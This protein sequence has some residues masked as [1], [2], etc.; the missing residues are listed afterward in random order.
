MRM[1]APVA[2]ALVLA[3]ARSTFGQSIDISGEPFK[4][5]PGAKAALIVFSD[6]QCAYS[7]GFAKLALPRLEADYLRTGKVRYV[8]RDLPLASHKHAF[9]A[10][11]AA[12]CA[13]A[14]GR[15]W[16]MHDLLF[17]NQNALGPPQLTMHAVG[18]AL[19]PVPFQLCLNTRRFAAGIERDMAD[20]RSAGINATPTFLVGAVQQGD[21]R[22]RVLKTLAGVEKYADL[23][24]ALDE[25]LRAA[26]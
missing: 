17:R 23:K 25:V 9:K 21:G 18:L 2:T 22:V 7:A 8:M 6:Y 16:E 24:A 3:L 5:S 20:A 15:F 14:Q 10:A 13:G 11:E 1:P 19:K 12:H 4:G 26:P